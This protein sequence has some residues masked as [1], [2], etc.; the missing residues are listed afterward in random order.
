[1]AMSGVLLPPVPGDARPIDVRF[2]GLNPG[3]EPWCEVTYDNGSVVVY[4]NPGDNEQL[5]R[6]LREAIR[7]Q[8]PADG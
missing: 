5:E 1:M 4:A 2:G 7:W 3:D 6:V 8:D